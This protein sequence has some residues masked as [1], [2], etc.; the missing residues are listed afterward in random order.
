M[1][2]LYRSALA[3]VLS[4][5][6]ATAAGAQTPQTPPAGTEPP[7][8]VPFP[9]RSV[10]GPEGI[11]TDVPVRDE[12]WS[13]GLGVSGAY[14]GNALFAG[15]SD[16]NQMSNSIQAS[17]A[18]S[19][20]LRRGDAQLSASASQAFYQQTASLDGFRYSLGAALGHPITRRLTWSGSVSMSSGLARDSEVLTDAGAVLPSTTT[21]R[22][23]SGSSNF[24][25]A[26]DRR[27]NINWSLSAS[28]AGFSSAEFHGGTNL[29][30]AVTYSKS[31]GASQTLGATADYQ[32]TFSGELQSDVYGILAVWAFNA[33]HGWTISASGG[34]T[35]YS[36]AT[37]EGL[38]L[39]SSY[40]AGVTKPIRRNQTIG[41]TYAKSVGTALGLRD[42]NSLMQTLS[43]SYGIVLHRNLSA[44]FAGTL[45][46]AA[47]PTQTDRSD[48]GQVLQGNLSY[49]LLTNL[50]LSI[51]TSYFARETEPAA[52]TTSTSTYLAISYNTTWR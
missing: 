6:L 47:D 11:V 4:V 44:S 21:A 50:S 46:D 8:Q 39:T 16:D 20:R 7:A 41:V 22:T 1:K 29:G 10:D 33:G 34:V 25:Y 19:W 43:A 51:G 26:L 23:S 14:E 40:S 31:V 35:P 28:G 42:G 24:S 49:R 48:L 13:F 17:L 12:P 36:V 45:T 37:E 27:S 5:S 3:V 52:R 30:T 9:G 32:R 38:Q 18:R 2:M 15:P